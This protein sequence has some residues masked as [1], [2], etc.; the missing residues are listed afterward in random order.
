MALLIDRLLRGSR[1]LFRGSHRLLRGRDGDGNGD[2]LDFVPV[3]PSLLL[4]VGLAT[5]P[6]CSSSSSPSTSSV[7]VLLYA[8]TNGAM[9][10]RSF[11]VALTIMSALVS[12]AT[13]SCPPC[14]SSSGKDFIV[15]ILL[16]M[17]SISKADFTAERRMTADL[18]LKATVDR[19]AATVLSASFLPEDPRRDFL[20][21]ESVGIFA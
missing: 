12:A 5:P 8:A 21:L 10:S 6:S 18:F 20:E 3:T 19:Y 4:V 17:Y 7:S 16:R 2:F 14:E 1:R 15:L 11:L 9:S 13:M